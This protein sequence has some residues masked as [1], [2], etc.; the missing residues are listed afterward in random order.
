MATIEEIH[1]PAATREVDVELCL[2]IVSEIAPEQL[3]ELM[4]QILT[5]IETKGAALFLGPA[6]AGNTRRMEITV[7]FA[8]EVSSNAEIHQ[9]TGLLMTMLEH[10]LPITFVENGSRTSSASDRDLVTA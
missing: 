4:V 10:E 5:T 9:K 2:G 8:I 1:T 6:V 3:D 7:D